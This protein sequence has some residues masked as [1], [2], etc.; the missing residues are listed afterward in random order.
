MVAGMASGDGWPGRAGEAQVMAC[1]SRAS[2]WAAVGREAVELDGECRPCRWNGLGRCLAGG[3]GGGCIMEAGKTTGE[4]TVA[5]H[6]M[7]KRNM[8]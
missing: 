3:V 5:G 6:T 8:G 2:G 4:A 1:A 7:G